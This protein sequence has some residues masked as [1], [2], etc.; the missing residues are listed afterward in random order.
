MRH[1]YSQISS[2]FRVL[3]ELNFEIFQPWAAPLIRSGRFV[4]RWFRFAGCIAGH[5]WLGVES[6]AMSAG[7]MVVLFVLVADHDLRMQ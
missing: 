7:G 2:V 1:I 5:V 3:D 4:S 6:R